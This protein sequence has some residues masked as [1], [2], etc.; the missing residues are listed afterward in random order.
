M[1]KRTENSSIPFVSAILLCDSVIT[2]KVSKKKTI[3]GV[4]DK[5][6]IVKFPMSYSPL[7]IYARLVGARGKYKF[8][9]DYIQVKGDKLLMQGELPKTTIA[10]RP[11]H[12]DF[13]FTPPSIPIPA[14]GHYEFRLYVNDNYIARVG[15]EAVLRKR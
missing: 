1:T 5:I 10:N 15:F 13:L 6:N 14:S 12:V 11:K 3:I 7:T 9:V 2:D 8:R 4:F